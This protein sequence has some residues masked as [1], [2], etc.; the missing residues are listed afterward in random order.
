MKLSEQTGAQ[1]VELLTRLLPP[2]SRAAQIPELAALVDLLRTDAP[3][4]ALTEPA[5]AALRAV[6][7]HPQDF[8]EALSILTGQ[9]VAAIRAQSAAQTLRQAADCVD[10]ELLSF[11]AFAGSAESG[12]C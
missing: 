11:F 2:L 9:S 10:G 7:R 4:S 8:V 6:A 5:C 1:G 3:L 12:K